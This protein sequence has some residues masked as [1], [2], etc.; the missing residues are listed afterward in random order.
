MWQLYAKDGV[1]IETNAHR[2]ESIQTPGESEAFLARIRYCEIDDEFNQDDIQL[3]ARPYLFKLKCYGFERE[4]R[5]VVTSPS[6]WTGQPLPVDPKILI[7]KVRFSP[8]MPSGA[9]AL[10]KEFSRPFLATDDIE[11]SQSRVV[12]PLDQVGAPITIEEALKGRGHA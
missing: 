6:G 4:A 9:A 3:L 10:L 2:L 11:Q 8:F 7:K 5:W 1:L 12:E